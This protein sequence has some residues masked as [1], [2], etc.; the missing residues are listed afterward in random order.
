ML[1]CARS[2]LAAC[3]DGLGC[4]GLLREQQS[5]HREQFPASALCLAEG[6]TDNSL[7]EQ[8]GLAA[9]A[10]EGVVSGSLLPADISCGSFS[11]S[12]C[13]L[14]KAAG[15]AF[16]NDFLECR[17]RPEGPQWSVAEARLTNCHFVGGC[18][19][20]WR[21]AG[22][23]NTWASAPPLFLRVGMWEGSSSTWFNFNSVGRSRSSW[24]WQAMGRLR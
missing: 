11:E 8:L 24:C 7:Q 13:L 23:T 19:W 21:A 22:N 3:P 2:I 14:K 1:H 12:F 16:K 10:G 17:L 4:P 5:F 9:C 18:V 15:S 6:N 20:L